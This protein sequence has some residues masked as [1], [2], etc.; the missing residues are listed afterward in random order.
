MKNTNQIAVIIKATFKFSS[1]LFSKA[2]NIVFNLLFSDA[3]RK[4]RVHNHLS[5]LPEMSWSGQDES[6]SGME[7]VSKDGYIDDL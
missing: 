2:F 4:L 7:I 1:G 5:G 3:G 6:D